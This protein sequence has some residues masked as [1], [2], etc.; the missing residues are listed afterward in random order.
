[1]LSVKLVV[2]GRVLHKKFAGGAT[3]GDAVFEVGLNKETV[4]PVLNGEV[5]HPKER[6]SDGDELELIK[7][8]YGG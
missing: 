1:M 4:I 7:I 2:E 3:V 5:A 8:I 6:L